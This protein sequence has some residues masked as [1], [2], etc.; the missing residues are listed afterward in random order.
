MSYRRVLAGQSASVFPYWVTFTRQK[1]MERVNFMSLSEPDQVPR[2]KI[3]KGE[4]IYI[5]SLPHPSWFW[6]KRRLVQEEDVW[7]RGKWSTI[8]R[9]GE[10]M[11]EGQHREMEKWWKQDNL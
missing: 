5:V 11:H 3:S 6:K 9:D 10:D 4:P 8:V 1:F 2:Q 7:Q